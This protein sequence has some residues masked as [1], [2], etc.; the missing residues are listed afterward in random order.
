[1]SPEL[2]G[3]AVGLTLSLGVFA[4]KAAAGEYFYCALPVPPRHK[5]FFLLLN[6]GLYTA[7]F[8]V[9]F[10]LLE[11]IDL[12]RLAGSAAAFL[13]AGTFLHMLLAAG[14]LLWGVKLLCRGPGAAPDGDLSRGWLLLTLPCPV[15][16]SAI[17]LA[18]AFAL[19]LFPEAGGLLRRSVPAAFL[20]ANAFFL[21][22]LFRAGRFF[23][24]PPLR[25]TGNVMMGTGL[26][27]LLLLLIAPR[28]QD[29]DKLY[30]AALATGGGVPLPRPAWAMVLLVF[31]T[32]LAGFIWGLRPRK[33]C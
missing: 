1:M 31:V 29:A 8:Y 15:C 25:L 5:V 33:G 22:L 6:T 28:F 2:L 32:A 23:R 16:A 17:F 18:S 12:F 11:R 27:F 30:A 4:F 26:Y 13:K 19:M 14:L 10:L 3:T 24:I 20:A 21:L 7:V 9:S